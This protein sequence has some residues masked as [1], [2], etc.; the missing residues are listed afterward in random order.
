MDVIVRFRR[1]PGAAEQIAR[2]GPRGRR[3]P[4]A[5]A[6]VPLDVRAPS[7][8]AVVAGLAEH[9]DRRV[10]GHRRAR[11][12]RAWTSRAQAAGRAAGRACPRAR[13]RA[14][15]SRSRVVDSGVAQHPEHPDAGGRRRLRRRPLRAPSSPPPENSVDPNGHG[16]HVAG[17]MVGNG[18]H[19]HGRP[20]ARASPREASLV[21]VRVLDGDGQRPD[22]GR[23][24][25]RCSGSWT[26]R[27]Q[28]GIRVVNLSLGHPV[29]EPADADPLVQAVDALWDAGIVV[30]CSAGNTGRDGHG[31]ISSP[32]NSRKVI[33]VGAL[34]DR[35][36]AGHLGR[37]RRHLLVAR[38]HARSTSWPSP[39]SLA[40]GNRIVSTA[41]RRARTLDLAVPRAPRRRRPGAALAC[42]STSRCPGTSMAAPM[43]AGTAALMLEQDP[44][45]NPGTVKA[46]L[47][48]SARKA[49]RGRPVRHRRRAASTSS[50]ALRATGDGRRRAVA[51]RHP[52]HARPA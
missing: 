6:V 31:T 13:S 16:T 20:A 28:Y 10:R 24:G 35:N 41:R 33:T 30:V 19:S 15:A 36:T 5:S 38:A 4:A 40:P 17:I 49:A 7:R 44:S 43:V 22:L 1:A 45:L 23:A 26:T 34:N 50:A 12:R 51:A 48:L 18:S 37:H 21:S 2:H 8:D 9:A 47:M 27:T 29:Y 46:R 11:L 3:A 25:R 42:R 32:C 52:G 14:R 39:T